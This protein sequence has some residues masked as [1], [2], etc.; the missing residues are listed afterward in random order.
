M[1]DQYI[2]DNQ[3]FTSNVSVSG[4][5][6]G[7]YSR[8]SETI[9][10]GITSFSAITLGTVPD[11]QQGAI[12]ESI[13]DPANPASIA[14]RIKPLDNSVRLYFGE[15]GHSFYSLNLVNVYQFESFPSFINPTGD[16]TIYLNFASNLYLRHNPVYGSK[17]YP[18]SSNEESP[19][20]GYFNFCSNMIDSPSGKGVVFDTKYV[21]TGG[22]LFQL[23]NYTTPVFDIDYLGTLS[24]AGEL[25]TPTGN[26]INWSSSYSIVNSNSAS[27][28]LGGSGEDS[29]VR[30]LTGNWQSTYVTVNSNS[31]DWSNHTDL[32]VR[33]L[34]SNWNS[35]YTIVNSNSSNWN[36]NYTFTNSNSSNWN[37]N[38]TTVNANSS[39]WAGGGGGNGLTLFQEI[40]SYTSPNDTVPVH[41][42]S[43]VSSSSNISI[44]L[45]PKG[46]G[47]FIIGPI[48]D[49]TAIGGNARGVN[50]ID[51]QTERDDATQVSSYSHAIAIGNHVT[52]QHGVFSYGPIA[53]GN[54]A[55]T[56]AG[57]NGQGG[58][59]SIGNSTQAYGEGSVAIGLGIFGY[60]R[61]SG[62]A[63]LALTRNSDA[64]G[65]YSVAIQGG[66]ANR[67]GMVAFGCGSE[68][69]MGSYT[70]SIGKAQY[71]IFKSYAHTTDDS[72]TEMFLDNYNTRLTITSGTVLSLMINL[73]GVKSDGSSMAQYFR[74]V[75][76]KNVSGTTSLVGSVETIGTDTAAGTS[77]SITEDDGNDALKIQV[78]G[79]LS[80]TWRWMAVIEGAEMVY[81]T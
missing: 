68:N 30:E 77:I 39:T 69:L 51:I 40:S 14:M 42:L 70:S 5:L 58:A 35:N 47:S 55:Y 10:N 38:Y 37:S 29:A 3:I 36:S 24:A 76:I 27:W 75:A 53:I 67:F 80:E 8:F 13:T 11:S 71:V 16:F 18:Y 59:I 20:W 28:G 19:S 62:F 33:A 60:C 25:Y 6:Q 9:T 74:K 81:G 26:S 61:A 65:P 44:C 32:D 45:S 52:A 54:Y 21:R 50:C 63:S 31:S 66:I 17:I 79:I 48:P 43:P 64:T 78:T 34:T 72:P 56:G 12:F 4:G 41:C 46:T 73:I 49:S 7:P 1:S 15:S 57:Y 23:Y 2:T 22:D